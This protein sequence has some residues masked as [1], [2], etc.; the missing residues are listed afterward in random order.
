MA[1]GNLLAAAERLLAALR[2]DGCIVAAEGDRLIVQG[3]LTDARR[4]AIIA[5]KPELIA[6]LAAERGEPQSANLS[7]CIDTE[8][9]PI[10][11]QA[12]S[13][14]LAVPQ[15]PTPAPLPRGPVVAGVAVMTAEL[16]RWRALR[17][18][19]RCRGERFDLPQPRYS[20]PEFEPDDRPRAAML[21]PQKPRRSGAGQ[22]DGGPGGRAGLPIRGMSG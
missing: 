18:R 7:M 10:A 16:F 6:I 5:R 14:P 4:A 9:E 1:D 12:A 17:D 15:E 21:Y 20:Y 13:S 3:A 22:R 2:A 11:P 19:A 8:A